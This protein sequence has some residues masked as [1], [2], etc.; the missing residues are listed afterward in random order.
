MTVLRERG[1]SERRS[2]SEL[3]SD[4]TPQKPPSLAVG[5]DITKR[6]D[7][8]FEE[9]V[10][11]ARIDGRASVEDL[12]V[13]VS[14]PVDEVRKLVQGLID[15]GVLR[16]PHST[17][18]DPYDGYIFPLP[19]LQAKSDLD[20]EERKKIIFTYDKL[21]TWNYY[22][23]LQLK[24]RDEADAIKMAYRQRVLDW[25]PDAWRRKAKDLGPFERMITQ[26]FEQVKRAQATL[27]DPQKRA[28]YDR[29]HAAF[30]VDEDDLAEMLEQQRRRERDEERERKKVQ[31]RKKKNPVR[32]RLEKARELYR[33]A[34]A[35]EE[36]GAL[37]EALRDAQT[38]C[39]FDPRSE[40][41]QVL[42]ERLASAAGEFRIGP[43]MKKG[44]HMESM[45]RW[46]E[47]IEC[48]EQAVKY[49]P[50]HGPARLRL[51]YNLLHGGRDPHEA[52]EHARRATSLLSEEPEAHYVLG[53]CYERA[54][55]TKAAVGAYNRALEL[56]P[57]YAE[58][59]KRLTKLRWG[60]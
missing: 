33:R 46:D 53:L 28:A 59:K 4:K 3:G 15:K 42:A 23:L 26:I 8:S 2:R 49:A 48:F 52:Q 35:H 30:Y 19:L 25:H 55:K 22:E 18:K 13:M 38:A 45:T 24:R 14:M 51:A 60:F 37:I 10:L 21:E 39:T 27:A 11:A 44:T 5:V 16:D 58:V 56:R 7:L 50:D 54:G 41:Y 29:E 57:T 34:L 43:F 1:P 20:L 9:G 17:K 40:E 36:A 31:R 32:Q 47:A 12:A 6:D